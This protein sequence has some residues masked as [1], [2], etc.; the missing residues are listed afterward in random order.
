MDGNSDDETFTVEKVVDRKVENGVVSYLVKWKDFGEED[1]TWEEDENLQCRDLIDAYNKGVEEAKTKKLPP[2]ASES[3]P[4]SNSKSEGDG[5]KSEK[6]NVLPES[7]SSLETSEAERNVTRDGS[8]EVDNRLLEIKSGFDRGLKPERIIGAT[9]KL[10]SLM[11]LMK[12]E[13]SKEADL[14]PASEANRR[15]PQ[16]VIQF[17]EE[18]LSWGAI[19]KKLDIV[20]QSSFLILDN[21]RFSSLLIKWLKFPQRIMETEVSEW[22]FVEKVERISDYK[23]RGRECYV[24]WLGYGREH[25]TWEPIGNIMKVAPMKV[26]EFYNRKRKNSKKGTC[27]V[28]KRRGTRKTRSLDTQLTTPSGRK[29]S[30]GT[31][32]N[33]RDSVVSETDP[34]VCGS[35]ENASGTAE[36]SVEN[37]LVSRNH[38]S[39]IECKPY[40][41]VCCF[42]PKEK[43]VLSPE[44]ALPN[45]PHVVLACEGPKI[46][47][48]LTLEEAK[49]LY[50]FAW[51]DFLAN[52]VDVV[53]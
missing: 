37:G 6:E 9:R 16:T 12:W 14:V 8:S 25:N 13:R 5:R 30:E 39:V 28:R 19:K 41:I 38:E 18:R 4:E 26:E 15:C 48:L 43:T 1:N 44:V 17:Y 50:P 47:K 29:S 36:S 7:K 49:L 33:I 2:P 52:S 51:S 10:G 32:S 23:G 35:K 45:V 24:K 34:Y 46:G 11:F 31:S 3:L 22:G 40:A 20:N 42:T 27:F 21:V 53:R